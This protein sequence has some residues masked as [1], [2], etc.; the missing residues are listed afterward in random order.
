M[1]QSPQAHREGNSDLDRVRDQLVYY[2]NYMS[3]FPAPGVLIKMY[4]TD[5]HGKAGEG[6]T[7]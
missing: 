6:K 2:S 7:E 4:L 5:P 3:Q 1:G